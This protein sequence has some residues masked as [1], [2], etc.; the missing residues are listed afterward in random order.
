MGCCC[1]GDNGEDDV[2]ELFMAGPLG[3]VALF[4]QLPVASCSISFAPPMLVILMY[5]LD[6][7][8][9][10]PNRFGLGVPVC[11]CQ[12]FARAFNDL[13][14]GSL[15]RFLQEIKPLFPFHPL[16]RQ[17]QS[18]TR[19]L[20]PVLFPRVLHFFCLKWPALNNSDR[21]NSNEALQADEKS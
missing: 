20:G 13:F 8:F 1:W 11:V 10:V 5:L 6:P 2:D 3:G 19:N 21:I 14:M 17:L 4:C 18:A 9:F 15:L 7:N 12:Q 16:P